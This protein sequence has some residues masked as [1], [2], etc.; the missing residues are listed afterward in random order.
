[1]KKPTY[2][3]DFEA[4][5]LIC[6]IGQ[7]VYNKNFVAAND[8]NISVK[9]GPDTIWTTPTGVSKGFMRPDM[10]VKMNLDGKVLSGTYKPSSEVK[11]HIRAYKENPEINAVVHAHPPVATSFAISGVE[12]DKP[13][14]PEAIVL[15]GTVPIAPYATPG[16][17]EVP[18]SIAPYCRDYNA[19]LLA[20]HGALTWGR[21]LIEA[22]YRMESLEHY[23]LMT[24]YSTNI[25]QRSNELNCTQ[26]SD[27]LAI[28]DKLGIKTG[29]TPPCHVEEKKEEKTI[30]IEQIVEQVT[31]EVL[32]K[33]QR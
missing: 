29:G 10:M 20:N 23:A 30:N 9:C 1:M 2:Y 32:K 14:S 27:L 31:R 8:G 21:D 28:R 15:L 7:R 33:Y 3:S 16:T 17:E 19:V 6:D 4:K 26:V 12:L 5:K 24:M 25:I 18:E 22:Y 11:M 13:I